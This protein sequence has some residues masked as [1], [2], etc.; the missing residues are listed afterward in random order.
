MSQD[1][2]E[3]KD[4]GGSMTAVK[5]DATTTPPP[6]P[7][8]TITQITDDLNHTD[9]GN[10]DAGHEEAEI[11]ESSTSSQSQLEQMIA[12]T[13]QVLAQ[14]HQQQQQQQQKQR[15]WEDK[16]SAEKKHAFWDTQPMPHERMS[17]SRSSKN[18]SGREQHCPIVPNKPKSALR[19]EPYNMPKGFTWADVDI[20]K[21]DERREVYELLTYNYVEDDDC[22]FRFD[23]SPEFILWA[24]TPP[25]FLKQFHLGVRST[26][27]NRLMA[28]ITGVP[29]KIHVYD[30]MVDVV[31]INFLCV[32][33]KLRSK[34]LAP[35]LIKEITRRVNHT[36]VFQAVYTA[37]VVLPVPV[38]SCRYFHRS[39]DPKKL[40]EIGFSRL[41]PRMTM[42]RMQKLYRLPSETTTPRLRLMTK[43]DVPSAHALLMT[44][45]KKFKLTVAF[46]PEEFEHWLLPR[47]GVVKSYV[48][49]DMEGNVTDL[50]SYYHLPSSVMNNPKHT[51]LKAAY[52]FYNV[53]TSVDLKDLMRDCLI[54]ARRE[55]QDVFNAL[56][57]MENETFLQELKFG[58]GDGNLQYYLYNWACPDMK[59]N[60]V[61][62]V[63]L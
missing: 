1:K 38:A 42:A 55:D 49:T 51:T 22:M 21:E 9:L 50:C 25:G 46:T 32:H 56:N 27:S 19:A 45:L 28:L 4:N 43:K 5:T 57:L 52:S 54:L 8:T 62:I 11:G 53:A 29:A 7:P 2:N 3:K 58:A 15:Q 47:D 17:T 63:F 33:K 30:K 26:K 23:Y 60:D 12:M 18:S 24:L 14:R 61:G 34:R 39:L 10:D 35:V 37:G 36:G 31:E 13:Q 48:A 6:P 41:H 16:K 20:L 59:N 44:Y 40:V